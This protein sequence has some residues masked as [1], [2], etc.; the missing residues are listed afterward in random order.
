MLGYITRAR[1]ESFSPCRRNA[2]GGEGNLESFILP[3]V[4]AGFTRTRFGVVWAYLVVL[5]VTT[6]APFT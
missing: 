5:S 6:K 1:Q 2:F 3:S 4:I